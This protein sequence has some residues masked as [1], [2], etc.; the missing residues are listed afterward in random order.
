M[1]RKSLIPLVLL[2]FAA[3]PSIAN[4]QYANIVK[5]G[6]L[7]P[8]IVIPIELPPIKVPVGCQVIDCCPGC[9]GPGLL[10]WRILVDGILLSGAEVRFE[11][12][13]A[14]QVRALKVGG[15]A[16]IEGNRVL[17]GRG[18]N[19]IRN[20]P[21]IR[22]G[23]APMATIT[24]I[25]DRAA[26][27]RFG[28]KGVVNRAGRDQDADG[29]GIDI[30]VQQWLGKYEVNR[31]RWR[32]IVFPCGPIIVPQ[33]DELR[34][35]SITGGDNV[36]VVMD[37]RL[38]A[39]PGPCSDDAVLRSTG[40]NFFD[41]VRANAGCVSEVSIFARDNAM[42]FDTAITTWTDS[43]GDLHRVT[44]AP[45]INMPVSVWIADTV[46]G[47]NA[48]ND[49]ANANALYAANKIGVQFTATYNNVSADANAVNTIGTASCGAV[50][51]VRTSAWYTA[52][53]LNAYYVNGAFTGENC[54]RTTPVGDGNVNYMGTLAN[55]ASLAHEFGHAF[56][57]RPAGSGGHTN[58]VAGFGN[59]NIMWG[60]GPPGR[61]HFSIGQAFRMNT[62]TDVWGGTMLI[63]NGLRAGARA[64]PPNTTSNVCPALVL[65]W[66][67]P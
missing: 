58:A 54:A 44:L 13:N 59:N 25:A 51:A 55:L 42:A 4:S 52:N 41:N 5:R 37:S 32:F 63:N 27:Q 45:I 7:E 49:I 26:A 29:S 2:Y 48:V 19:T 17:L 53:A 38:Q 3:H 28:A 1:S 18:R 14:E 9:P 31:Y 34:T 64:C 46:A 6:C 40:S 60:G 65:D 50:G 56:G 67:R 57:L 43:R 22:S 47:A 30:S 8:L 39:T 21:D 24:P 62:H 36:V 16:K 66:V 20:L 12:L 61:D 35:Q 23:R 11:G 10:E 15:N 33:R